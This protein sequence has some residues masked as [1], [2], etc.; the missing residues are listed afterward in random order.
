MKIKVAGGETWITGGYNFQ[1]TEATLET[2]YALQ[3]PKA[4][5][6]QWEIANTRSQTHPLMPQVSYTADD[7]VIYIWKYGEMPAVASEDGMPHINDIVPRLHYSSIADWSDVYTWYKELAKGR[8]T[9]DA[10]IEAKVQHLIRDLRTN[11]AKIR[12]IYNF[13]ASQIRYVGIELGQSAYQP[14]YATEVFQMQYGDCKDKTTLLIAM[15]DL[16]RY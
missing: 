5:H 1:S 15:L 14:S 8:Y 7:T 10:E 9:P 3:M 16:A 2:S 12:A 6:L 13:V 11:A 4:W